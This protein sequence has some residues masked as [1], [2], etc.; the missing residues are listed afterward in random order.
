MP[1]ACVENRVITA[2]IVLDGLR[3]QIH[4]AGGYA[5]VFIDQFLDPIIISCRHIAVGGVLKD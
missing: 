4:M 3:T 5:W 1:L 2:I